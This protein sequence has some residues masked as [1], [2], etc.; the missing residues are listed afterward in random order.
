MRHSSWDVN[1]PEPGPR[2]R[3]RCSKPK[4]LAVATHAATTGPAAGGATVPE[5]YIAP[6]EVTE[7]IVRQIA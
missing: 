6:K 2:L 7:R 5:F 1:K 4:R 3:A